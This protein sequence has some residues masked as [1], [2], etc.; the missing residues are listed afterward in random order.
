MR[1]NMSNHLL[2]IKDSE[3]ASLLTVSDYSNTAIVFLSLDFKVTGFNNTSKKIYQWKKKDILN[4]SYLNWCKQNKIDSPL[5]LKDKSTLLKMNPILNVENT[6]KEGQCV[7][8]W[9]IIPNLDEKNQLKEIILIGN[10][11]TQEKGFESQIKRLASASKTMIGYDIGA[12]RRPVEYVTSVYAYLDKIISSLPCV[13]FWK[14]INFVYVSCNDSALKILNLESREGLIGKTD[15]DI[16]IDIETANLNRRVDKEIIRSKQPLLNEEHNFVLAD[17]TK[18]VYLLSKV[19]IFDEQGDVAGIVGIMVDITEEKRT[20]AE[21]IK[22]KEAAE[23]ANNL[24]SE[25]IHNMEHDIRTPFAGILGMTSILEGLELDLTKK[26]M[27]KDIFFC[28]Q[29][30]LDYSCGIIDFSRIEAGVLPVQTTK[31]NLEK[32]IESI[33]AIE[34]PAAKMKGIDY[35]VECNDDVP[36]YVIGDEYRLK[37]ILINLLSNAIK[38]TATGFVKLSIQTQKHTGKNIVLNF[39]VEDTGI[40]IEKSRLSLIYEKFC[41]V[42]PSNRGIYKGQGLGLRI[43]KKFVEE[44]EGKIDIKSSVGKGSKFT[45]TLL[46]K[47]PDADSED[48]EQENTT[49]E[50]RHHEQ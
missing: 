7:I 43:V 44:M 13:V 34:K 28:A 22:A 27:I 19:P 42:M 1:P 29:E 15:F 26:Q 41:R 6:I 49:E 21:L 36:K 18:S 31:F 10:D 39:I 20:Q 46:F 35:I 23:A 37:R 24:K 38:F 2:K 25:F 5:S 48:F 4:M 8:S 9:K 3:K 12:G 40:G 33:I 50:V 30:L 16:G 14:D 11:I 32:L 17:G 47:I 45:C